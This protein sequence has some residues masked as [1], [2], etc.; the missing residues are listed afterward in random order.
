GGGRAEVRCCIGVQLTY[1]EWHKDDVGLTF[2]R[3][4]L[5]TNRF[6]KHWIMS[7][8][9]GFRNFWTNGSERCMSIFY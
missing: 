6:L 7:D 3:Y 4:I 2:R 1:H 5:K 9:C 8:D